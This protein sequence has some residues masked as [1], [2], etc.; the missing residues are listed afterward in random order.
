MAVPRCEGIQYSRGSRLNPDVSHKK[1]MKPHTLLVFAVLAVTM[2]TRHSIAATLYVATN[3][4]HISPFTSW[5]NAAT[6]INDAVRE[7]HNGDTVVV[8]NGLYLLS[9]SILLSNSITVVSANGASNP[10]VDGQKQ[11]ACFILQNRP[12]TINGFTITHGAGGYGG[13]VSTDWL[14]GGTVLNCIIVSNTASDIGAG[15]YLSGTGLIRNCLIAN[16]HTATGNTATAGGGAFI[17]EVVRVENCTIYNNS[18][19]YGGGLYIDYVANGLYPP[20]PLNSNTFVNTICYSNYAPSSWSTNYNN[21][22]TQYTTFAFCNMSPVPPGI[23][24]IAVDPKLA[25][26]PISDY[27]LGGSS[28]CV[29]AGTNLS[30]THSGVDLNGSKR[31]FGKSVDIGAYEA[32]ISTHDICN[33]GSIDTIWS[34]PVGATVKLSSSTN[35]LDP[36]WSEVGVFTSDT[37]TISIPDPDSDAIHK[38]YKLHWLRE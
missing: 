34:V 10:I 23:G 11:A 16:N 36:L 7:T 5:Q 38:F 17:E 14:I 18:S 13:G 4:A 33:T 32:S 3:G 19:K 21:D 31:V 29:N 30:W 37:H 22:C 12:S 27:T 1:S 6:S 8:S 2:A 20:D 15:I 9:S 24:N 35:L 26:V 25:N 28:P